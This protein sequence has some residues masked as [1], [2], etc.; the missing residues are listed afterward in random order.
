MAALY[1]TTQGLA[2]WQAFVHETEKAEENQ[3]DVCMTSTL[4]RAM[5]DFHNTAI[6]QLSK[7]AP[8]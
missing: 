8:G 4:A 6:T 1:R 7:A 3:A 5:I 2:A